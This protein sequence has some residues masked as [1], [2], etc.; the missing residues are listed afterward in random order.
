LTNLHGVIKK[1]KTG[2]K[3]KMS[4]VSGGRRVKG[5]GIITI[6]DSKELG[7][8]IQKAYEDRVEE[9]ESRIEIPYEHR[10]PI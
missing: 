2:G 4:Y 10:Q 9:L 1:Q 8:A 3:I 7:N 5:D 6:V